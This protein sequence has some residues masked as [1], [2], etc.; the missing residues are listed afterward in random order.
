M[1]WQEQIAGMVQEEIF[2]ANQGHWPET[3]EEWEALARRFGEHIRY[4]DLADQTNANY[5]E[6]VFHVPTPGVRYPITHPLYLH[7]LAEACLQWDGREPVN[8]PSKGGDQDRHSIALIVEHVR[9]RPGE[10]YVRPALRRQ[11]LRPVISESL[12]IQRLQSQVDDLTR[13]MDL[14]LAHMGIPP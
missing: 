3:V 7:E 12:A 9:E 5:S 2:G 14:L 4:N 10:P 8:V 13:K 1:H 11:P 6:G